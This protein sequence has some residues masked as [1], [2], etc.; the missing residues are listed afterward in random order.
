[1]AV[2]DEAESSDS[3]LGQGVVPLGEVADGRITVLLLPK[4]SMD[5]SM[6]IVM[7][8]TGSSQ[9]GSSMTIGLRLMAKFLRGGVDEYGGGAVAEV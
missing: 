1:V 9:A 7:G 8:T 4:T 3:V 2:A 6:V 5:E